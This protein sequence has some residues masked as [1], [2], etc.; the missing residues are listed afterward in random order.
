MLQEAVFRKHLLITELQFYLI[1]IGIKA[2][3]I[4]S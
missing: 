3:R 1:Q 4:I 2:K